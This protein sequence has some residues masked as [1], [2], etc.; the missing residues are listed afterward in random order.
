[1][2]ASDCRE[3]YSRYRQAG[4]TIRDVMHRHS[5]AATLG[6]V[7]CSI[8]LAVHAQNPE[9]KPEVPDWALPGSATHKQVAP[10][11]DF[12]RPTKTVE[13]KIGIFDGQSDVGSALVEGSASFDAA[14][15]RYTI[16]SAGYN[17]WYTR[18]EF[19]FLWKK[20]SGDISLAAN[21][22]YPIPKATA[23]ARPS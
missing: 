10:P 14:T 21:I 8:S 12:H 19:R 18:D 11:P 5:L 4:A 7:L 2:S 20:M 1:M 9:Q 17:I 16:N 22:T 15:K 3:S 23:I 13:G 6:T